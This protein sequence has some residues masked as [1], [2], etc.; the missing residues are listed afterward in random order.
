MLRDVR[1]PESA[2]LSSINCDLSVDEVYRNAFEP[3]PS[4]F[5]L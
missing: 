5:V 1:S 2:R 3:V 4:S